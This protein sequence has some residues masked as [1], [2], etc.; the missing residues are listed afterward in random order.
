MQV[1]AMIVFAGVAESMCRPK[2]APLHGGPLDPKGSP[3]GT[4]VLCERLIRE[5]RNSEVEEDLSMS[6]PLSFTKRDRATFHA[7][8]PLTLGSEGGRLLNLLIP[9]R[10]VDR[11]TRNDVDSVRLLNLRRV[12][13]RRAKVAKLAELAVHD[14]NL[15]CRVLVE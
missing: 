13:E 11:Q 7:P 2:W 6:R 1:R 14:I 4:T 12:V 15:P 3:Q 10:V 8:E 9:L 5:D